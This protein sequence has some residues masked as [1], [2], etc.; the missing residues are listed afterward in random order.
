M[1]RIPKPIWFRIKGRLNGDLPRQDGNFPFVL[2]QRKMGILW[3]MGFGG[4]QLREDGTFECALLKGTYN[5]SLD[6]TT[7]LEAIGRTSSVKRC[8][9]GQ[10][11]I[12]QDLLNL[13]LRMDEQG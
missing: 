9:P 3:D 6:T 12:E 7:A 2:F 4:Y 8:R 1:F 13:D 11:T 10:V 5:V